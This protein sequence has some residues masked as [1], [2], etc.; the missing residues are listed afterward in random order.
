VSPVMDTYSGGGSNGYSFP[1]SVNPTGISSLGSQHQFNSVP[2]NNN[3]LGAKL[4]EAKMEQ[5]KLEAELARLN[6]LKNNL[7]IDQFTARPPSSTLRSNFP[8][9]LSGFP[10][11]FEDMLSTGLQLAKQSNK[12]SLQNQNVAEQIHP[13]TPSKIPQ[14]SWSSIRTNHVQD[15]SQD[16]YSSQYQSTDD[17]SPSERIS[18]MP[19]P[20]QP[21]K[22]MQSTNLG[23]EMKNKKTEP[24]GLGSNSIPSDQI[25]IIGPNCYI[26]SNGGF[27]FVGKAPK[28]V[29]SD[30]KSGSSPSIKHRNHG[31][32]GSIWDSITSIP[33]VNKFARNFGIK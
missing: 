32:S 16:Q 8:R 4:A 30:P 21:E 9:S 13:R 10:M 18:P 29:P 6:A 33:L 1:Q 12:N 3:A 25:H 14:T 31:R 23:L 17:F 2:N 22:L 20:K 24:G 27:K 28:C 26:M 11:N 5:K 19:Q 7:K 15:M